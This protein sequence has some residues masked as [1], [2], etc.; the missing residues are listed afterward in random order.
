MNIEEN[1][2]I[3]FVFSFRTGTSL[4][5]HAFY[6]VIEQAE[7]SLI[8]R[9]IQAAGWFFVLT[10]Q[11]AFT[12]YALVAAYIKTSMHGSVR[13]AMSPA[14][15]ALIICGNCGLLAWIL[16]LDPSRY[17]RYGTIGLFVASAAAHL[18]M[19]S[20][21]G[22]FEQIHSHDASA[23]HKCD[24]VTVYVLINAG[25]GFVTS[26]SLCILLNHVV[27]ILT[28]ETGLRTEYIIYINI[29]IIFVYTSA[30]FCFDVFYFVSRTYYVYSP[31]ISCL[32]AT[33]AI[34]WEGLKMDVKSL[35]LLLTAIVLGLIWLFVL[36]KCVVNCMGRA[37]Q[38]MA[39][40]AAAYELKT[41]ADMAEN[42]AVSKS[43]VTIST[44]L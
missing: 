24:Y 22:T 38:K 37:R 16:L 33:A 28:D 26:W 7:L 34:L 42:G 11:V 41:K 27:F 18:A 31:Y 14:V 4:F 3:N 30:W 35:A 13:A 21:N 2:K 10:Y 20:F 19:T 12:A 9:R 32:G 36:I 29:G 23:V 5:E 8:D 40:K 39:E 43:E 6:D 25:L 15:Q 1:Y 17:F 44:Y